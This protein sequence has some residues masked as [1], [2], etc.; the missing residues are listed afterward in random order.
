MQ[1]CTT[2]AHRKFQREPKKLIGTWVIRMN[3]L[4]AR[5]E[6]CEIVA[7]Q[8]GM[9]LLMQVGREVRPVYVLEKPPEAFEVSLRGL[10]I[11]TAVFRIWGHGG[12]LRGSFPTSWC[13]ARVAMKCSSR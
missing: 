11:Q 8:R 3:R 5:D 9:V 13:A 2:A 7:V 10:L 6:L 1:N 12:S 4:H